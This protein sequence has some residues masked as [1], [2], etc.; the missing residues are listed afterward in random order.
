M[1]SDLQYEYPEE[2]VI[3]KSNLADARARGI[4]NMPKWGDLRQELLTPEERAASDLRVDII[5]TF[6]DARNEGKIT[7]QEFERLIE[8]FESLAYSEPSMH[9]TVDGRETDSPLDAVLHMMAPFGMTLTVAPI[10]E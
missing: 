3:A 5:S 7:Q 4:E 8:R 10:G 1:M 2:L 9:S 6:I